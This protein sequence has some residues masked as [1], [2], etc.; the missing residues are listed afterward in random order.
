MVLFG[1]RIK[2]YIN[3]ASPGLLKKSIIF[4]LFWV[5]NGLIYSL[6]YEKQFYFKRTLYYFIFSVKANFASNVIECPS[7][8]S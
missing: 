1:Y 2:K 6:K 8:S 7:V 5:R 4:P 3:D